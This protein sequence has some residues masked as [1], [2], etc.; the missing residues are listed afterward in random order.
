MPSVA[1]SNGTAIIF[2]SIESKSLG[3]VANAHQTK[4]PVSP[5]Y[6]SDST[7]LLLIATGLMGLAGVSRKNNP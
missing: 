2:S 6:M 4:E 1:T 7:I 3:A 5:T